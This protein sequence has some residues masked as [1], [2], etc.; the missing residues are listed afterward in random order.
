MNQILIFLGNFLK[1]LSIFG[2]SQEF[3]KNVIIVDNLISS[4]ANNMSNGIPIR[5]FLKGDE[6]KELEYLALRLTRV[7]KYSSC[8]EFIEKEFNLK[9]FYAS[10]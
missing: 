5:P 2:K 7:E 10:V 6:D 3:L 4:F 8:I 9:N 1:D